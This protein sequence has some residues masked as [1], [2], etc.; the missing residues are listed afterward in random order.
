MKSTQQGRRRYQE[1]INHDKR[2]CM[3]VNPYKNKHE[4]V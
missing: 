3:I 4:I 2:Y 1:N